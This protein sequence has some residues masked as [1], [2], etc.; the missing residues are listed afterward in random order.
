MHLTR[1]GGALG[2]SGSVAFNFEH[3]GFFRIEDS[4]FNMDELELELIDFGGEELEK[5]EDGIHIYTDFSDYGKMQK[6]LEEKNAVILE[7][8]KPWVPNVQIEL[9]GGAEQEVLNLIDTLEEDDDVQNVW[10][11]LK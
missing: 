11:N 9:E 1:G 4:G 2:T 3:K 5:G 8:S 6:F 7:S 10:H